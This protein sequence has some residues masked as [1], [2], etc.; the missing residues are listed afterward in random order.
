MCIVHLVT[1]TYTAGTGVHYS[2]VVNP[3]RDQSVV[4]RGGALRFGVRGRHRHVGRKGEAPRGGER[5]V[6]GLAPPQPRPAL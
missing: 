1:L 4:G 5:G 2:I 6:V 3:C